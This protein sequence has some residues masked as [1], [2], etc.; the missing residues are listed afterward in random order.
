MHGS[1]TFTR[2]MI[3]AIA[4][5]TSGMNAAVRRLEASAANVA[6]MPTTGA[7]PSRG[8]GPAAY[9]PV[10]V[11]Q[12]AVAGGGTLASVRNVSPLW[13]VAYDPDA[14]F[15][16]ADGMVAEPDVDLVAEALEQK[17]AETAFLANL[18]TLETVQDMV[19]R[20]F[21]LTD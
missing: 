12:A 15:A 5:A 14:T 3:A 11:E 6:N 2:V 20:L 21:E 10:G 13:R 9:Q 17:M 19:E 16:D 8:S 1:A 7:L 18:K 4:A